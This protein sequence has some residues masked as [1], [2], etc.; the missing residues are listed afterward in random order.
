M[1]DLSDALSILSPFIGANLDPV[2]RLNLVTERYLKSGDP[3]GSLELVTFTVTS[4]V[5]GQGF[6]TLPSRYSA[7]RGAVETT[8][9]NSFCLYPLKIR[10]GWYEFAPGNLGMLVGSDPM[11]GIIPITNSQGQTTRQYKV[12][13]CP[14]P[15]SNAYFTCIC[16]IAFLS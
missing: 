6:I 5:N 4:D 13:V 9:A 15:G 12:P 8:I 14:T 1:L 7:I 10:N 2:Q 11:R 16:K 3:V